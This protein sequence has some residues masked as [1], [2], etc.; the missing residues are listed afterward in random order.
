MTMG[1]GR[2]WGSHP[3]QR[4]QPCLSLRQG[5][6]RLFTQV[7]NSFC[8]WA[9]EIKYLTLPKGKTACFFKLEAS[10]SKELSYLFGRDCVV[11]LPWLRRTFQNNQVKV[12]MLTDQDHHVESQ[13]ESSKSSKTQKVRSTDEGCRGAGARHRFE[14]LSTQDSV[15]ANKERP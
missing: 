1:K 4:C 3:Q 2:G 11:N 6:P 13:E 12:K 14:E 5:L 8:T 7:W 15:C 9:E 10:I